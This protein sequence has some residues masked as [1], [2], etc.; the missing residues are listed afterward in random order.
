MHDVFPG[1]RSELPLRTCGAGAGARA[2]KS[3]RATKI[4]TIKTT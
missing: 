3:A 4:T 1:F 2:A